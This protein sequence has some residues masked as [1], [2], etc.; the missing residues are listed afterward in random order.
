MKRTALRDFNAKSADVLCEVCVQPLSALGYHYL[1]SFR[2]LIC[3]E[4]KTL[5]SSLD[6]IVL[7]FALFSEKRS[8]TPSW[9]TQTVIITSFGKIYLAIRFLFI[10]VLILPV[11]M[12]FGLCL[13][14]VMHIHML[15]IS[16]CNSFLFLFSFGLMSP[17]CTSFTRRKRLILLL[18]SGDLF[19]E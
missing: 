1:S 14:S 12:C 10:S 2:S 7:N 17:K 15:V 4:I 11:C 16:F 6:D 8:Y 9:E 18:I 3:Q 13:G 19:P 5:T